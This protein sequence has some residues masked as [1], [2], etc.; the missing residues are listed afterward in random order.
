MDATLQ[1][2]AT[3]VNVGLELV[4][5]DSASEWSDMVPAP[6]FFVPRK[7]TLDGIAISLGDSEAW[8]GEVPFRVLSSDIG[9]GL[10]E[11][12]KRSL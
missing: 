12:L 10:E 5:V 8:C 9:S 4:A 2:D 7:N 11:S 1:S 3:A 6:G